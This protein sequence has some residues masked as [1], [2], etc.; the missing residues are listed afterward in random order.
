MT[1]QISYLSP[2]GNC[3]L[4][5]EAFEDILEDAYVTDLK[6]DNDVQGEIHLV[7]FEINESSFKAIPYE[8][9]ELLDQLDGKSVFVF[10]TCPFAVD[11]NAKDQLERSL[12]P[13]LPDSCDYR[14]LFLCSG[15]AS[16]QLLSKLQ[17]VCQQ[18][19]EDQR[20]STLLE[21]CKASAG[22]PD[23]EDIMKACLYVTKVLELD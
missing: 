17:T 15:E 9:M 18:N 21:S 16:Q 19:P 7:G 14:G 20:A 4:L 23:E 8:V 6:Y 11:Q 10:A 5:A 12:Q 22:H 3:R 1:Y 2:L 13:F